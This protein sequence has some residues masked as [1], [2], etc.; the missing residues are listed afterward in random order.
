MR[1]VRPDRH[2]DQQARP[3][4]FRAFGA[5]EDAQGDMSRYS[6][7]ESSCDQAT[8]PLH[9]EPRLVQLRMQAIA[10]ARGGQMID[11]DARAPLYLSVGFILEK[12]FPIADLRRIVESMATAA[13]D[14][15]VAI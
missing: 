14:A 3:H 15:G 1:S 2:A 13:T 9:F 10:V 5:K 7:E 12:G 11:T 6:F 8:M 4:S